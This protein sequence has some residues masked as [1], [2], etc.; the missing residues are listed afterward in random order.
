MLTA[1][2]RVGGWPSTMAT[3]H[4]VETARDLR[5]CAEWVWDHQGVYLGLDSETNAYDPWHPAFRLRTV[6]FASLDTAW[7]VPAH[8]VD[9][10]DETGTWS[11]AQCVSRLIKGHKSWVCHYAE[12]DERFTDRGLP[13]NPVRWNDRDP[14]FSDSQTV[15][16]MYDPRTVTTFSKKDRIHPAIPRR[17]G[18]KD[19][20]TR[21]LSRTLEDAELALHTRFRELARET[22]G[23]RG[24]MS[25]AD[26]TRWGFANIPLDDTAYRLYAVLDPLFALRLFELCRQE[27]D[28]QGRW[29]RAQAALREQW[30]IDRATYQGLPVDGPYAHWLDAQ[31]D[32]VIQDRAPLLAHYGIGPSGLGPNVGRAFVGLGYPE[33]EKWDKDVIKEILVK[34]DT[35]LESTPAAY[36]WDNPEIT[37][38]VHRIRDL[39]SA[40]QDVRKAGKYQT[41]WVKPMLW[42]LEHADG[43]MHPSM[44]GIGAVTTRMTCQKTQTAGPLHS[45]PKGDKRI[46]GAVR[47]PE[48]W[49]IVTADF[50][51]AE[52]TVM[53]ARSGDQDYLRDLQAGDINSILAT[54]VYGND[55]D[56]SQGKTAGTVHY[57]MRQACKFAWLAWCYGAGGAKIDKLL[58]VHTGV[59]DQWRA[60]YPVFAAYRDRLNH[61]QVI[62]L[63]SG[64]R[65]P[66]WDRFWVTDSGELVLRTNDWGTPKL[67]RLGLNADTQGTQADLLKVSMHRI[68]A[69]GWAWALRFFVHDEILLIVPAWMASAAA[70]ML[71][72]AMTITYRGVVIEC[73]ATI[74]GRTWQPQPGE[75]KLEE[76]P[77]L[78]DVS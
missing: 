66:L 38:A 47:A 46:R 49:V 26:L 67:S 78:E 21:L 70:E 27:L 16:A 18:L 24:N 12:A 71:Q 48:G 53:A 74:E 45:A 4:I 76:L 22:P 77:E 50:R 57:E 52:P 44:R 69:W 60:R 55:Y 40:V 17:R 23:V 30:M 15:L 13:D 14:H 19:N 31:L 33:Q 68:Q 2:Y 54:L 73:E 62:E 25:Q 56:P 20:S 58:G 9:T 59:E 6:Q 41:N 32:Q 28:R 63:D 64:H 8:G 35:Y 10:P 5:E 51:Q 29:P 42:T 34:A 3:L 39:S 37:L 75:F 65:V 1:S 61:E 36:Q 43:V 72:R 11:W 7:F